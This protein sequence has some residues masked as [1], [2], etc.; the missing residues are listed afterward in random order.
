[1]LTEK[2]H[3]FGWE[4]RLD[5]LLSPDKEGSLGMLLGA[6]LDKAVCILGRIE[7]TL[8][9]CHLSQ[10]VTEDIANDFGMSLF[11]GHLPGFQIGDGQLGLIIEHFLEM[12]HVPLPVDR[13]TVKAPSEMVMDSTRSHSVQRPKNTT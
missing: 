9:R 2:S 10:H 6:L 13:V 5:L 8:R 7:S 11:P 3:H 1:M 4:C 12:R